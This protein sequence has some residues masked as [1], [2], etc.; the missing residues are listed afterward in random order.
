MVIIVQSP[1]FDLRTQVEPS[2]RCRW[3]LYRITRVFRRSSCDWPNEDF[4][5]AVL[6]GDRQNDR[7]RAILAAILASFF[8]F[9]L[10]EICIADDQARVRLWRTH[11]F[12]VL[13]SAPGSANRSGTLAS[14]S[15]AT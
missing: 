6:F 3:D 10:P 7:A 14:R 12:Q 13:S 4:P 8:V 9:A 5:L 15:V 11:G 2:F 1:C